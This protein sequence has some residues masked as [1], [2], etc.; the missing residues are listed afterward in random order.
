MSLKCNLM[1][2]KVFGILFL[3]MLAIL[4]LPLQACK[5]S[6]TTLHVLSLEVTPTKML[7]GERAS[8]KAEVR[9]DGGK[10]ESYDIPLMVNGVADNRV[11]ATLAPGGTEKVE[12]SLRRD[13]AGIYTI[14]IGDQTATLEVRQPAPA[15]FK[16]SNLQITP[17][18]GEVDKEIVIKAD[19]TNVGEVK[20]KYVAELKIN[21]IV[22]KK[23]ET[24]YSPGSTSFVVF[25]I[26]QESPGTYVVNIGELTGQFI[27]MAPIMPIQI[28]PVCPPDTKWD[29][30]RK[31]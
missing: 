19:I 4:S 9:N 6:S 27:V 7:V 16:L 13:E 21:G 25:K 5:E 14:R 24:V 12:F 11:Y 17:A 22:A 18:V 1:N 28:T 30:T 20:G 15:T 26:S 3:F 10:M 29:T 31:C 8:V 2:T 23:D